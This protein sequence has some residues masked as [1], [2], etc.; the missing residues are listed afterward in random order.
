MHKLTCEQEESFCN[1]MGHS[2]DLLQHCVNE[3]VDVNT[4]H[5]SLPAP[6]WTCYAAADWPAGASQS[7]ACPSVNYEHLFSLEHPENDRFV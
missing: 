7:A 3:E 6:Q 5:W 4:T 1:Y 2:R